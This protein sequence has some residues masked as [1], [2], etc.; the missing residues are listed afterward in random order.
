MIEVRTSYSFT[1]SL[2]FDNAAHQAAGRVSDYGGC[3]F[4][5]RDLGWVC[6]SEIEAERIKRAL[7]KIGLTSTISRPNHPTPE[8]K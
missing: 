7:D 2:D 1:G 3:G 6:K 8:S 4:G 5:S